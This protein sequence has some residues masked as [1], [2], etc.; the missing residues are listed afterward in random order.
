MTILVTGSSSYL[1]VNLIKYLE[2]KKKKYL[3]VDI[4]NPKNKNCIKLDI[5][6]KNFCKKIGKKKFLSIVH[7]A[8]I[9]NKNDCEKDIIKCYNV[10][11]LG[12]INV[13]NFAN[14]F[15]IKRF[16]FA[17]SEWVYES[18]LKNK[19]INPNTKIPLKFSN[20]YSF[21]KLLCENSILLNSINYVILRFGIIYG[22]RNPKNFSAVESIVDQFIKKKKVII[23]SKKTSRNY[24]YIDDVINS[25]YKS[26]TSK[27]LKNHIINIQGPSLVS[28]GKLIRILEKKLNK[29]KKIQELNPKNYSVRDIGINKDA[30]INMLFRSKIKIDEGIDKI[31]NEVN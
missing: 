27:N 1:G 4:V 21:S 31:L 10:N 18:Y 12:T 9:S 30:K 24:I 20:H 19:K 28:L 6:D 26:I 22:K 11:L 5:Q 13:V 16:I 8:A 14:K 23:Q 2:L 7:L 15:K 29:K 17:S 25:I 3:G